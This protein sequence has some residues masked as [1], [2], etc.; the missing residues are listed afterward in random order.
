MKE[1]RSLE[2]TLWTALHRVSHS[3]KL[4]DTVIRYFLAYPEYA[5]GGIHP[6]VTQVI[7]AEF[8]NPWMRRYTLAHAMR[9]GAVVTASGPEKENLEHWHETI[10]LV[11]EFIVAVRWPGQ[12]VGKF[13]KAVFTDY[14][15]DNN[16]FAITALRT[17]LCHRL[18]SPLNVAMFEQTMLSQS[19]HFMTVNRSFHDQMRLIWLKSAISGMVR[20]C[21]AGSNDFESL[22]TVQRLFHADVEFAIANIEMLLSNWRD[23]LSRSDEK[24]QTAR[25]AKHE[26]LFGDVL[27]TVLRLCDRPTGPEDKSTASFK[28]LVVVQ[29]F[30]SKIVSLCRSYLHSACLVASKPDPEGSTENPTLYIPALIEI[31]EKFILAL[32]TSADLS[33]VDAKLI[34]DAEARLAKNLPAVAD[35]R[36][37]QVAQLSRLQK[38][39]WSFDVNG[40]VTAIASFGNRALNAALTDELVYAASGVADPVFRIQTGTFAALDRQF[41]KTIGDANDTYFRDLSFS[42]NTRWPYLCDAEYSI[43]KLGKPVVKRVVLAGDEKKVATP[44]ATASTATAA[45]VDEVQDKPFSLKDYERFKP[46]PEV[47]VFVASEMIFLM[48]FFFF[49][50]RRSACLRPSTCPIS[51]PL[52]RPAS[53]PRTASRPRNSLSLVC[54]SVASVCFFASEKNVCLFVIT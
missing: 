18:R 9:N 43:H 8:I 22:E 20:K 13:Q 7:L 15:L 38:K 48:L 16:D 50:L 47:C 35:A 23:V 11:P 49:R 10:F 46:V 36:P 45:L 33:P 5:F 12:D 31:F 14:D 54:L 30:R 42:F 26:I 2:T 27:S 17:F 3:H 37:P 6:S 29:S 28:K 34:A 41:H 24:D 40:L 32:R 19:L 25:K 51:R 53:V 1:V 44:S 39:L 52:A 21:V 4:A